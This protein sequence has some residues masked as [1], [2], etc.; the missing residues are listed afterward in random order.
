MR[1]FSMLRLSSERLRSLSA[2]AIEMTPLCPTSAFPTSSTSR[3]V[4][5]HSIFASSIAPSSPIGFWFRLRARSPP[6]PPPSSDSTSAILVAPS[7]PNL[8]P[9]R[10]RYWMLLLFLRRFAITPAVLSSR[11]LYERSKLLKNVTSRRDSPRANT[12]MNSMRLLNSALLLPFSSIAA[13][14]SPLSMATSSASVN[15]LTGS[16]TKSVHFWMYVSLSSSMAPLCP[17]SV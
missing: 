12:C 17:P 11:K 3:M 1:G 10:L 7:A 6:P 5:L 8:L 9:S 13:S 16:H 15:G 2:V 4:F 14:I